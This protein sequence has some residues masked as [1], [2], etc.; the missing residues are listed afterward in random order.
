MTLSHGEE[1][2]P[3]SGVCGSTLPSRARKLLGFVQSTRK[4]HLTDGKPLDRWVHESG[5]VILLGDACHPILVGRI[6]D[7]L[8]TPVV[9]V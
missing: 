5:R 4:W 1:E 8:L 6:V 7:S 9:D 2:P 3:I